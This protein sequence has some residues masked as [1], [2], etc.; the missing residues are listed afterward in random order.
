[1]WTAPTADRQKTTN[2]QKWKQTVTIK[3]KKLSTVGNQRVLFVFFFHLSIVDTNCCWKL[4]CLIQNIFWLV[5][6]HFYL[7]VFIYLFFLS[8][9]LNVF[10]FAVYFYTDIRRQ[11]AAER[12]HFHFSTVSLDSFFLYFL[13]VSLAPPAVGSLHLVSFHCFPLKKKKRTTKMQQCDTWATKSGQTGRNIVNIIIT[14]FFCGQTF[15]RK[16]VKDERFQ[17][18]S[19]NC[20]FFKDTWLV[21]SPVFYTLF[22]I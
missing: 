13:S 4:H 12:K 21:V 14:S 15:S 18:Q 9:S 8:N 3:K 10:M 6:Q 5:D 1:M 17:K 22:C 7:F 2:T 20:E 19:L 11:G 16:L